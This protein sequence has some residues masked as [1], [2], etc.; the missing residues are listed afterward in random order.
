MCA[1]LAPEPIPE[2]L[3]TGAASDL[4]GELAAP[5]AD[6]LAWRQTL[7]HVTRQ[8]LARIDHQ[9]LQMH[10]L[11]QAIL[12]DRL[13]PEQAAAIRARTEAILAAGNPGDPP[14]PAT[15]PW[16]MRLMPHLLAADLAATDSPTLR[17]M[18]CDA[19]WYMISR[20]NI[21]ACNDLASDLREQWR[22]RSGAD[23]PYG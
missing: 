6:P 9:G 23:D 1:F 4:P 21:P 20:G 7:A 10:R 8:S 12:R 13:A 11:T 14:N 15:W 17:Q 18:V 19:C 2:E 22:E 3:F 16:W 5:V